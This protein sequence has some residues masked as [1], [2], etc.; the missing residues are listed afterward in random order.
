MPR[1][2]RSL[3]SRWGPESGH[4]QSPPPRRKECGN[5][6]HYFSNSPGVTVG[7]NGGATW[8]YVGTRDRR[9]AGRRVELPALKLTMTDN[10]EDAWGS[11]SR[12]RSSAAADCPSND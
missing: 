12:P 8:G 4:L 2:C 7:V 1:N 10:A 3:P 9:L 5:H 6:T 11:Q